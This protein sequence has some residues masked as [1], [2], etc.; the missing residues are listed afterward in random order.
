MAGQDA[1]IGFT[2]ADYAI[3]AT[4][5]NAGRSIM[6][7]HQEADKIMELDSH[8]LLGVGG[9]PADCVQEPEHFQ[10]NIALNYYRHNVPMST[11]AVANYIRGEKSA[12]LRKGMAVVDMLLA[13]YDTDA[14]PSLYFIDYLASMQK[15]DKGAH[16]YCGFF[17]N[18]LLDAHWKPG[19]TLEEGLQL[20]VLCTAEMQRRFSI[21]SAF[22]PRHA[23]SR[24]RPYL[25]VLC[26]RP[27][28]AATAADAPLLS[29]VRS[30]PLDL[31]GRRQERDEGGRNP[32]LCMSAARRAA[33][34]ITSA[35]LRQR[36]M[37]K[38]KR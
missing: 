22:P 36:S 11:H 21:S 5:R 26:T 16:G 12:K 19:M 31:Q 14:G 10:K 2:G 7:F 33:A 17:V 32:R 24:R 4:D 35:E 37:Y 6:V 15:L 27:L 18:S 13:G 30:A 25:P 9:D 34:P 8:K 23:T 29:R 3:I 1:I 28:R 38:K 20:M